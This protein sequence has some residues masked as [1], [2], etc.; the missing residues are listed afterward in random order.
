M[1]AQN[2]IIKDYGTTV[3]PKLYLN[4]LQGHQYIPQ[5]DQCIRNII[6]EYCQKSN[7]ICPRILDLGCGPG[8]LT[9]SIAE[10]NCHIIGLDISEN[11][12]TYANESYWNNEIRKGS[13]EFQQLDFADYDAKSNDNYQ[14]FDVI[15]MQGV[16]HHIHGESRSKFIQKCFDLLKPSGILIIGDE[17][18]ADYESED[19]RILNAAKFYLHIIN[20]A[21]K[22]GFNEL[23]EEEAKNLIDDCF[24]GTKYAGHATEE[25]FNIIYECAKETNNSFYE[26]GRKSLEPSSYLVSS[27]IATILID[28]IKETTHDLVESDSEE[29][30]NRGDYKVSLDKFVDEIDAYRFILSETYKFGPVDQLG[31][32]GV[33]VFKKG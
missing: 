23:A 32:M 28:Q 5:A 12:I 17:F 21:M 16:M 33:L 9:L 24:S 2:S 7:D 29:N 4:T 22:G 25:T 10:N 27:D 11:F 13:V 1:E 6:K 14:T 26:L 19:G 18:I 31:G 3:T 30:F 20:E 15:L 8:R